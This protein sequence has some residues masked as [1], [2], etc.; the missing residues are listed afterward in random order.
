MKFFQKGT[1]ADKDLGD[2]QED[3]EEGHGA[4]CWCG[5]HLL[6]YADDVSLVVVGYMEEDLQ[7]SVEVRMEEFEE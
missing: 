1:W 4:R 2:T 7:T 5:N 6:P 3:E